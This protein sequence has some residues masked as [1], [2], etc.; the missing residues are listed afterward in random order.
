MT[1]SDKEL[2]AMIAEALDA[3]DRQL[4]DQFGQEPGY[5]SQAF[6]LF[7][8]RLGWVMWLVYIVNMAAAGLAL[9]A[10]WHLFTASDTL[11]A[12]RWGV[13]TL[14]AMQVGLFMKGFMGEQLQHNR[15]IREVKRLE[16]QLVRSQAR[17]TA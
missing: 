12:I 2:D 3:E 8:G 14:A 15:V 10:A 6:G 17:Q 11:V 1:G 4:L 5:F 7:G 16:L 9:W 13:A